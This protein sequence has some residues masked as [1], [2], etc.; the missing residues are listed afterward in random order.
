MHT[1]HKL[2]PQKLDLATVE[3]RIKSQVAAD[4][5]RSRTRVAARERAIQTALRATVSPT[6]ETLLEV[7][8]VGDPWL[9]H[10]SCAV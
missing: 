1:H 4:K 9:L 8:G 10:F 2:H 7:R 3:S 6:R 5:A